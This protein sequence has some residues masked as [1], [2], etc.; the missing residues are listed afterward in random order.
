MLGCVLG[1]DMRMVD[2]RPSPSFLCGPIPSAVD[3]ADTTI[4]F[5]GPPVDSDQRDALPGRTLYGLLKAGLNRCTV[6]RRIQPEITFARG[7]Y[8]NRDLIKDESRTRRDSYC[9]RGPRVGP[10]WLMPLDIPGYLSGQ[11]CKLV[12]G[13]VKSW[14]RIATISSEHYN[15]LDKP[16]TPVKNLA[17]FWQSCKNQSRSSNPR[18]GRDALRIYSTVPVIAEVSGTWG[19]TSDIVRHDSIPGLSKVDSAFQPYCSG[20]INEYQACLVTYTLGISLQADHLIWTSA[21]APQR[22]MVSFTGMGTVGL[23][24]YGLLRH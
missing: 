20:S 14:V 4:C 18:N 15:Q 9:D 21:H 24:L 2:F 10:S 6:F 5:D 13:A 16:L 8:S 19:Y 3:V 11:D 12:D 7:S 17:T 1:Y 23:G 22:P